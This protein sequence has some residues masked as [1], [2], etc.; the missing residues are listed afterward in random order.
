MQLQLHICCTACP[1]LV[2]KTAHCAELACL[3]VSAHPLHLAQY[4]NRTSKLQA[5]KKHTNTTC[6]LCYNYAYKTA[7]VVC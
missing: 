3:P 2:L 4:I 6:R 7:H 1:Y 5:M